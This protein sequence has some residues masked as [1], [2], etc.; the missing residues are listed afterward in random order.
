M[1]Q[2]IKP[3]EPK[4]ITNQTGDTGQDKIP[5]DPEGIKIS[6][7]YTGASWLSVARSSIST[8]C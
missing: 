4:I 1:V 6:C 3:K 2:L 7:S 5:T 8:I